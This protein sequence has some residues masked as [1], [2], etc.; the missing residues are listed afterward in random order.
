MGLKGLKGAHAIGSIGRPAERCRVGLAAAAGRAAARAAAARAAA[1][2]ANAA[3]AARAAAARAAAA[4]N[5]AAAARAA[6][7]HIAPAARAKVEQAGE[8][9]DGWAWDARLRV[10]KRGEKRRRGGGVERRR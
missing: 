8:D 3:A 2:A 6:S 7:A 4:A 5:A 9:E 1:A 10:P